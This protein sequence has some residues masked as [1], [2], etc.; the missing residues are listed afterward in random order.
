MG[1]FCNISFSGK[2]QRY[3]ASNFVAQD[4]CFRYSTSQMWFPVC[5][6]LFYNTV[7]YGASGL[8]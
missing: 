2:K 6:Q 5:Y 1:T 4:P 7:T 3:P 8:L